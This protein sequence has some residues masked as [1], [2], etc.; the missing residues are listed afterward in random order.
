MPLIVLYPSTASFFFQHRLSLLHHRVGALERRGV[1]QQR[2]DEE[3]ALVLL[4]HEAAR[5]VPHENDDHYHQDGDE[6][7]A[8]NHLPD[9]NR[10][11]S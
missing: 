5:N 7:H 10:R 3:K 11:R 2:V 8:A 1:G 6:R 4:G 9:E